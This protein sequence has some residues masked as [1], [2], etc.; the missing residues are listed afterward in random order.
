MHTLTFSLSYKLTGIS[1]HISNQINEEKKSRVTDYGGLFPTPW[2]EGVGEAGWLT[3]ARLFLRVCMLALHWRWV[4]VRMHR[5]GLTVTAPIAL[6]RLAFVPWLLD[7]KR[8]FEH[9]SCDV[10]ETY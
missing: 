6:H 4:A 3:V 1:V 10:G 2:Q 5:A 7:K 8:L 9:H